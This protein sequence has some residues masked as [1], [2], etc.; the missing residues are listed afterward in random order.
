[1]R[2]FWLKFDIHLRNTCNID[3][4]LN[5][6]TKGFA[7]IKASAYVTNDLI[8]PDGIT[9]YDNELRVED[10]T[11]TRKTTTKLQMNLEGLT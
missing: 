1:M 6:K 8:K 5:N 4:S 11:S 9:Y 7:F 10:A 2:T 3:F